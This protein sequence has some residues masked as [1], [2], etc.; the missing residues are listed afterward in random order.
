MYIVTYIVEQMLNRYLM[1]AGRI[2]QDRYV[3]Y[4]KLEKTPGSSL[5][6][7]Y[8][9]FSLE[10]LIVLYTWFGMPGPQESSG[11]P[12]F[13]HVSMFV[14][15]CQGDKSEDGA[16]V[17]NS[18]S[19]DFAFHLPSSV[20]WWA[21]IQITSSG[22]EKNLIQKAEIRA[23]SGQWVDWPHST[24]TVHVSGDRKKSCVLRL[25]VATLSW[26][27]MCWIHIPESWIW[28]KM[29]PVLS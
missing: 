26:G 2:K 28:S 23:P 3:S 25:D 13:H 18:V 11:S 17:C 4:Q 20:K 1:L 27:S 16:G 15:T 22:A 8:Q 21:S 6:L 7:K 9:T 12:V 14:L 5:T 10:C 24:H 29:Y 19:R